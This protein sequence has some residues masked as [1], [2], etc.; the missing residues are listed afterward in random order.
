MS[1]RSLTGYDNRDARSGQPDEEVFLFDASSGALRCVSCNPTGARPAGV[2]D[3]P[4]SS[5]ACSSITGASG[6]GK[7]LAAS[8][9]GWTA[10]GA[11]SRPLPVALPLRL[12]AHVL[13]RRRRARPRRTRTASMDVYEYEPP[14]V[15]DCTT[16]SATYCSASGGC[17]EPDLLGRL[18][19]RIGLPRRL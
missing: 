14:G 3:K 7:W 12:R 4:K 11:D 15:G 18:E 16:A 1:Q 10:P 5:R 17:V 9:P 13:Q 6:A 8:V 19:G 2:F